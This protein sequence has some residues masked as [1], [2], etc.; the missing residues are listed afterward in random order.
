MLNKNKLEA[1][2]KEHG[3]NGGD[4]SAYLGIA[5]GTFS[6]KLNEKN[7]AEFTQSEISLIKQRYNLTAENIDTIFFN[8]KVS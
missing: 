4:L 7:G 8:I 3:D 1:V 2:M 6:A 5:R